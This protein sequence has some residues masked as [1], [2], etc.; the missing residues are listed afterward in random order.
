[1]TPDIKTKL[2]KNMYRFSGML[3]QN[4]NK[5]YFQRHLRNNQESRTLF[6]V[7]SIYTFTDGC[8]DFVLESVL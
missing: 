1:M 5:Y 4:F 7:D 6:S 8:E 2:L 3:A